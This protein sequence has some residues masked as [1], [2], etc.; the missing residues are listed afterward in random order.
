LNTLF[1]F[2]AGA[3]Y[4]SVDC[5]P[6]LPPLGKC[7]YAELCT[8]GGWASVVEREMPEI[9]QQ[10]KND[11]EVG[12]DL[13]FSSHQNLV[14]SFLRQMALYFTEF[15]P[16][17]NNSYTT[18]I[19]SLIKANVTTTF[20]T[21]N[22]ELLIEMA[23]SK[24][25]IATRYDNF[26]RDSRVMNLLKLHGSINF[27]PDL[28]NNFFQ[29]ISVQVA[30]TKGEI[31]SAPIKIINSRPEI[32][33]FIQHEERENTPFLPAIAMFAP[34]KW[35]PICGDFIRKQQEYWR[36]EVTRSS[37]IFI[38]GCGVH[39]R[40]THI[41]EP[42]AKSLGLLTYIDP[43]PKDFENWVKNNSRSNTKVIPSYFSTAI[44]QII[45]TI[46]SQN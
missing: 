22:Y 42:L 21:T 34:S 33:A 14:C 4:G 9:A 23:A 27:L 41:W 37:P 11:F 3:S 43:N 45:Q 15:E 38:I 29:N 13:L 18:L 17:L 30:N 8:R 19:E 7:L 25:K 26:T 1:L 28:G 35:T 24:L 20:A 5:Y 10:F 44:P 6:Y 40:D 31:L 46:K 36:I 32:K 39:D 16:G 12:M 2:G